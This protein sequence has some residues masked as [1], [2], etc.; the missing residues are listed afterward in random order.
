MRVHTMP[1]SNSWLSG[2]PS[3]A[4][5]FLSRGPSKAVPSLLA[6]PWRTQT[7]EGLG[8]PATCDLALWR[9]F[10]KS[11]RNNSKRSGHRYISSLCW[12]H[13]ASHGSPTRGAGASPHFTNEDVE[14]QRG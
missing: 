14:A 3:A 1:G 5:V 11:H 13:S 10:Q 2:P 6:W 7:G 12:Y 4:C 8:T 9:R